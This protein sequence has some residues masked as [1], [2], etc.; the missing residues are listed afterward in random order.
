[1]DKVAYQRTMESLFHRNQ[2][3][4]R[5]KSE[6]TNCK[7]LDFSK[8]MSERDIDIEF[9]YDLL[10]QMVLHKRVQIPII[11]GILR[12]HFDDSQR[13]VDELY[14][15]ADAD[16][17]DW[18]PVT[19]Q[20]VIKIDISADV[21]ED[22]DR[23]Q[24]PI[25]MIIEPKKVTHNKMSGYLTGSGS[26]ILKNN[27]HEDDVCLDHINR[28]NRIK[29]S[30]NHITAHMIKNQW[31]GL[32]K[33]HEDESF[34]DYRR[35]VKQ[36]EKYDSTCKDVMNHIGIADNEFYLTHK[37]DKR[38]RVYCQGYHVTYQGTSWSKA[39]IE[40]AEGELVQ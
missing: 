23:Y 3:I 33:P 17:V 31:K 13:T 37:Y 32:D 38:G 2:L 34:Q 40:F 39:V 22:L 20:F 28:M 29:F 1:M 24:Y 7:E 35:R 12:K 9:G 10:T 4:P 15:C 30:I 11:V 16:L 21:K 25:P 8:Y 26:I 18:N 19:E 5:I 27:H 6:F 36:F 14:K